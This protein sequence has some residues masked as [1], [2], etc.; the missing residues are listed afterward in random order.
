MVDVASAPGPSPAANLP[1]AP[2]SPAGDRASGSPALV[3][4]YVVLLICI[5]SVW[6]VAPLGAVG[7][8]ASIL[9][10]LLLVVWAVGRLTRSQ[11]GETI[12]PVQWLLL[13]FAAGFAATVCAAGHRPMVS[14]EYE[15]VFR[16]VVTVAGWLG[17]ALYVVD[18]LREKA[19]FYSLLRLMVGMG[20]LLALVGL[21]QFVTGFDIVNNLHI[22]GLS[23]NSTAVSVFERAGFARVNATALHAIEFA[24]VLA[25][26]L[27]LAVSEAVRQRTPGSVLQALIIAGALPLTVSRSG[28]VGLAVGLAFTFLVVGTRE[29]LAMLALVP[30]GAG[31]F[32][33]VTPGLLGTIRDLFLSAGSDTSISARTDDYP[34]VEAFFRHA[35]WLGRGPFT[36]LPAVY[37][38]LDNQYLGSL[39]EGGVVGLGCLILLLVGSAVVALL[40][41]RRLPAGPERVL[42]QAM[43]ASVAVAAVLFST[44]DAFS[45]PMC[46][47][48]FFLVIGL[49]GAAARAFDPAAVGPSRAAGRSAASTGRRL[50]ATAVGLAVLV[51]GV[52]SALTARP[53]FEAR[54]TLAL[55]V[56]PQEG[57]NIYYGKKD[58]EG[59][60]SVVLRVIDDER[61]RA[62]LRADGYDG[63]QVAVGEGSLAPFTEVH[64]HGDVL[65]ISAVS[66]DADHAAATAQAV[67]DRV[68]VILRDLQS[69]RGIDPD[70]EVAVV[71]SFTA[72][73][74]RELPTHAPLGVGGAAALAAMVGGLLGALLRLRRG[75]RQAGPA[76]A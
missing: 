72:P 27:P 23:L 7:S 33:A 34:A 2:A 15:A 53:A 13:V 51:V 62:A 3:N 31:A 58:I 32:I 66:A 10:C 60:S 30:V 45:F 19:R 64:G 59:V 20:T 61:T 47:G 52:A 69:G 1:A 37:R 6:V 70:L 8:P 42:F 22:P 73:E 43:A 25:M 9:A 11:A 16:G 50:A 67:R 56:P 74:I 5:P 57:E 24:T 18:G 29:R 12:T 48:M 54:G 68:Q 40:V 65:R 21:A 41:A 36:F 71:E 4:T 63:Y 44:F 26:L 17:V 28:M 38:T 49:I 46:M 55:A 75:T 39:V 35:P 76:G 14:A